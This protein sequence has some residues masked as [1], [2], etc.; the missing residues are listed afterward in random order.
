V[1]LPLGA[2]L[3]YGEPTRNCNV[4]G[5]RRERNG[6]RSGESGCERG[7]DAE[8]GVK[9]D[10]LKATHAKRRESGLMLESRCHLGGVAPW[11]APAPGR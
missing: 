6:E 2:C 1:I 9:L 4:R 5:L 10:T 8:V 11:R 7:E 3:L